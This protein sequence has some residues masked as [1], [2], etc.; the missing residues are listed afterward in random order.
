MLIHEKEIWNT[1]ISKVAGIDEA[2]R[3]P[4]AGPVVAAAVIL[5]PEKPILGVN[6]SKKLNPHKR[7]SLYYEILEKALDVGIGIIDQRVIE[8][9][10]IL[11]A[12]QKAMADSIGCLKSKPGF[13]LIDAVK[14]PDIPIPQNPIIKGDCIS[15]SIAAASIV[16]KVTRD[17]LMLEWHEIYPSY[18]FA[19]NKGYATPDHLQ[20]LKKH[21]PCPIHRN[22]F[23]RIKYLQYE[24]FDDIL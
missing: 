5:S 23:K 14:L 18:D 3:G 21:G 22:T 20:A 11:R 16:A 1:G 10:N 17:K 4:L 2:G 12:T 13:L 7:L 9:L 6:D 8:E 19:R 15:A 24:L